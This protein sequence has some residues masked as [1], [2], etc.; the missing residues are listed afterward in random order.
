MGD[1]E[2]VSVKLLNDGS[3]GVAWLCGEDDNLVEL[4]NVGVEVVQS[5]ALSRSPAVLSLKAQL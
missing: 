1:E 3:G 5:W 4:R 2:V